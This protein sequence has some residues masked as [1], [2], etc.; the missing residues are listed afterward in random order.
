MLASIC[1]CSDWHETAVAPHCS[2]G[3]RGIRRQEVAGLRVI[4]ELLAK[5]T[6]KMRVVVGGETLESKCIQGLLVGSVAGPQC[7]LAG[8]LLPSL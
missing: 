7:D 2:A 6:E 4:Q 8:P 3:G 1:T 5:W